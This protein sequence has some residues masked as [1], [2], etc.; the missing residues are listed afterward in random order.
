M[1]PKS[2]KWHHPIMQHAL[3]LTNIT[4]L[5]FIWNAEAHS[6]L[7]IGKIQSLHLCNMQVYID[8]R[9]VTV[10]RTVFKSCIQEC[11]AQFDSKKKPHSPHINRCEDSVN[12]WA[13]NLSPIT[14]F[15][16]IQLAQSSDT[17]SLSLITVT[18]DSTWN[19]KISN[20]EIHHSHW[21]GYSNV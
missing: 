13:R 1:W 8:K 20:H 3:N 19:N 15:T 6:S 11:L 4:K 14:Q 12:D 7:L 2:K 9:W 10:S 21:T 5:G 17:C 16:Q 18:C